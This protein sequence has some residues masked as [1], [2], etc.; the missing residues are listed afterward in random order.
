MQKQIVRYDKSTL[1]QAS[2]TEANQKPPENDVITPK[3]TIQTPN[4]KPLSSI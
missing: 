2:Y 3:L 4:I 1:T